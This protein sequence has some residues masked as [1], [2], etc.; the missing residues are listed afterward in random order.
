[1][2]A[3]DIDEASLDASFEVSESESEMHD[4]FN[5]LR[6]AEEQESGTPGKT[7]A[8]TLMEM[9][10]GKKLTK[11]LLSTISDAL[12][13][14]TEAVLLSFVQ[15]GFGSV[16]LANVKDKHLI[17]ALM[18]FVKMEFL[19]QT[20]GCIVLKED[21]YQ[22]LEER[23]ACRPVT[24][25]VLD[26]L[27]CLCVGKDVRNGYGLDEV[28]VIN[29]HALK[30]YFRFARDADDFEARLNAISEIAARS[31]L[32]KYN[33]FK[34]SVF[35]VSLLGRCRH[36]YSSFMCDFICKSDFEQIIRM[37]D[38]NFL[39]N[40]VNASNPRAPT[41]FFRLNNSSDH[42][43]LGPFKA[44]RG[45]EIRFS[46]EFLEQL[47]M[48]AEIT[49]SKN[50]NIRTMF[51]DG[52][53]KS[54]V[55]LLL[56][57]DK[58]DIKELRVENDCDIA[59]QK[60]VDVAIT[61]SG[62]T[63]G[64]T[65]D[66]ALIAKVIVS[67]ICPGQNWN[68]EHEVTL[69]IQGEKVQ[70]SE[71]R[72]YDVLSWNDKYVFFQ[73]VS[74]PNLLSDEVSPAQE[75]VVAGRTAFRG[76]LVKNQSSLSE[77]VLSCGG[78]EL[79]FKIMRNLG[80]VIDFL[81]FLKYVIRRVEVLF[82]SSRFF[83]VLGEFLCTQTRFDMNLIHHLFE[84]FPVTEKENKVDFVA[85]I[86]F[87]FTLMEQFGSDL[88]AVAIRDEYLPKVR[89]TPGSFC[90]AMTLKSFLMNFI[91]MNPKG[92]LL[93]LFWHLFAE[94]LRYS[95]ISDDDCINVIAVIG[96]SQNE[97]A[98]IANLKG[99]GQL[100]LSR[101]RSNFKENDRNLTA[102]LSLFSIGTEKT[103]MMLFSILARN[104][105]KLLLN[106]LVGVSIEKL[107]F[108]RRVLYTIF[109]NMFYDESRDS[110]EPYEDFIFDPNRS[111]TV[112][113]LLPLF[114]N[115]V[116][117]EPD[118]KKLTTYL[119]DRILASPENC[120]SGCQNDINWIFLFIFFTKINGDHEK[121]ARVMAHCLI[122]FTHDRMFPQLL[123][124]IMILSSV[125]GIDCKTFARNILSSLISRNER[126]NIQYAI[127]A[128]VFN[129]V[130]FVPNL[131]INTDFQG[132]SYWDF[133]DEI[134]RIEPDQEIVFELLKGYEANQRM[135]FST[136]WIF[137]LLPTICDIPLDVEGDCYSIPGA[138]LMAYLIQRLNTVNPMNALILLNNFFIQLE[139]MPLDR[140]KRTL[141][142]SQL[143][144]QFREHYLFG[145]EI[146]KVL[147]RI[148]DTTDE[149]AMQR[150][151]DEEIR[152]F[153]ANLAFDMGRYQQGFNT[154]YSH[155]IHKLKA[156]RSDELSDKRFPRPQADDLSVYRK[157]QEFHREFISHLS[158]ASLAEHHPHQSDVYRFVNSWNNRSLMKPHVEKQR[159]EIPIDVE[160]TN[161]VFRVTMKRVHMI[162]TG[163]IAEKNGYCIF[164][165]TP[166]K[167]LDIHWINIEC[168][169]RRG[170]LSI[171][172]FLS[173]GASYLFEFENHGDREGF[174][175]A[176]KANPRLFQ[177]LKWVDET[178]MLKANNF[179]ILWH[180]RVL[181]NFEYLM[182]LN[183]L[184]GR[185]FHDLER[186]PVFPSLITDFSSDR[187]KLRTTTSLR[188]LTRVP[189]GSTG[190]IRNVVPRSLKKM[191]PYCD[192]PLDFDDSICSLTRD[193]LESVPEF[194]CC[195]HAVSGLR[196]P[197][198]AQS[199]YQF[200]T[201]NRRVLESNYVSS[202][203][204]NWFSKVFCFAHVSADNTGR[205]RKIG[206]DFVNFSISNSPILSVNTFGPRIYIFLE[207]GEF[208]ICDEIGSVQQVSRNRR[209]NFFDAMD[210]S[211]GKCA[212]LPEVTEVA[213]LV[214]KHA[215][216][217]VAVLMSRE[218]FTKDSKVFLVRSP[219]Q[220]APITHI[221]GDG[222][223]H[224]AVASADTSVVVYW[225]CNTVMCILSVIT[226][227][228]REI[229]SLVLS[230]QFGIVVA[231]DV[232]DN[233]SISRMHTGRTLVM[234][235]LDCHP[236]TILVAKSG[237]LVFVTGQIVQVRDMMLKV[238]AQEEL[239]CD[240]CCLVE[241][242]DERRFLAVTVGNTISLVNLASFKV[243][244]T[245]AIPYKPINLIYSEKTKQ[246]ICVLDAEDGPGQRIII[247][248]VLF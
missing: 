116:H 224:I 185:S 55:G 196:L 158:Q 171:E 133:L 175:A 230:G 19:N 229:L 213:A 174:L 153:E 126:R 170:A 45:F 37:N 23:L 33:C 1:M 243:K 7:I 103:Q 65:I 90:Q 38:I 190:F 172:L 129:F 220:T 148:L 8:Q 4:I 223:S 181:S 42:Y 21:D 13:R 226:C 119:A 125:F 182:L 32:T 99:L 124:E 168:V 147:S 70:F 3:S 26:V 61:V 58:A 46:L 30:L 117:H 24:K 81:V 63:F 67:N 197:R 146:A 154:F 66:G 74:S 221:T 40:C 92:E 247:S 12:D 231:V 50:L 138:R 244:K 245:V 101:F 72:V 98:L 76:V 48:F 54:K 57:S 205:P 228:Q 68:D 218:L 152:N 100:M 212:I 62:G 203:L 191:Y 31:Q 14:S 242:P 239:V 78:V 84:C 108:S 51:F 118:S 234:E 192:M 143:F 156:L 169:L 145:G 104:S 140:E 47:P 193:S 137:V 162:N 85:Q 233:C 111:L 195:P 36:F 198:W 22:H 163:V 25:P 121:W 183:R 189:G 73:F 150:F 10:E 166:R 35:D 165:G 214:P 39:A 106:P 184:N 177:K 82:V 130:L 2:I 200:V 160:S 173:S 201:L 142:M 132:A 93:E 105:A 59:V 95:R 18:L 44:N 102:L 110:L 9:F 149:E 161:S 180:T 49:I 89:E 131:R 178:E 204:H 136:L 16:L 41:C 186:Y 216:F 236:R 144:P 53:N 188:I 127:S 237:V 240:L 225:F 135:I 157:T 176:L 219:C 248:D 115:F 206:L 86:L 238:L 80:N 87:N 122:Q 202:F 29:S 34:A 52:E 227:H 194:F 208:S 134:E 139:H 96:N 114:A 43:I 94:M 69:R 217:F 179:D 64:L 71:V 91:A 15:T 17:D 77:C 75:P 88:L 27:L 120:I 60:W 128:N 232:D 246:L 241:L 159:E 141:A 155:Y 211:R 209:L 235:K 11:G 222:A 215:N 97:E 164:I 207:N 187:L 5:V 107:K 199:S 112:P 113:Q 210:F 109:N 167:V 151:C 56:N 6:E 123:H 20:F 28:E 79:L 83:H